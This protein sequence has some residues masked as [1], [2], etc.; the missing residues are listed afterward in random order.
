MLHDENIAAI[1]TN[2]VMTD[3]NFT[4]FPI[5]TPLTIIYKYTFSL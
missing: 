3:N 5:I 1:S 4:V 2:A